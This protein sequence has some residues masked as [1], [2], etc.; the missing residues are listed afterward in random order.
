MLDLGKGYLIYNCKVRDWR[1]EF[2]FVYLVLFYFN[3]YCL[4]CY[5]FIC[6]FVIIVVM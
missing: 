2:L 6:F 3:Y 4:I 5:E 1:D